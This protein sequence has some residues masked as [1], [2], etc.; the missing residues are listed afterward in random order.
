MRC[1]LFVLAWVITGP[2]WAD[3]PRWPIRFE[4]PAQQVNAAPAALRP[5]LTEGLAVFE[6]R[7]FL[8]PDYPEKAIDGPVTSENSTP[9]RAVINYHRTLRN[10]SARE[11]LAYW[12]RADRDRVA[13]QLLNPRALQQSKAFFAERTHVQLF[14]VADFAGQSVVF[15]SYG[16]VVHGFPTVKE[17]G[18]FRLSGTPRA[19]LLIA[20]AA[21]ALR[22]GDAVMET[23]D[24]K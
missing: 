19:P 8:F 20:I 22:H 12:S 14:G 13:E 2:V 3:A 16:G 1:F 18:V 9:L 23:P 10:R 5:Y 6:T 7:G 17:D 11:I 21:A 15:V 4:A 24:E